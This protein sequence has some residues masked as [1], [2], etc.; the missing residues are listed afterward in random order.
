MNVTRQQ[1]IREMRVGGPKI[2][3]YHCET[4]RH[5]SSLQY[6]TGH[7]TARLKYTGWDQIN[8]TENIYGGY[9]L[10]YLWLFKF[11]PYILVRQGDEEN[12]TN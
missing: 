9:R 1:I 12:H 3:G 6:N 10:M 4:A 8:L 11:N 5:T 7:N 2:A